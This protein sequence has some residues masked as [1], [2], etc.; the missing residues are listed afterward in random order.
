MA[1]PPIQITMEEITD[2]KEIAWFRASMAQ[3]ARNA[4]WLEAHANEI[5]RHYRGKFIVVA[6][7]ELFVGDTAQEALALAKAAHPDDHSSLIRYIYPKKTI[8]IYTHQRH[9]ENA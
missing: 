6:G 9:L 5:Y 8:R 4:D 2:P 7:E 1:L 3:V